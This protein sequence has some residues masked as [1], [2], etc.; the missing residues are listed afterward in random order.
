MG[1]SVAK[2]QRL[3][4]IEDYSITITVFGAALLSQQEQG[5][6]SAAKLAWTWFQSGMVRSGIL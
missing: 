6:A 4:E 5:H 3:L 2:L 1:E